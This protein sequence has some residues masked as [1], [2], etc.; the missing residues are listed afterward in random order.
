MN[1]HVIDFYSQKYASTGYIE[2][3]VKILQVAME[4]EK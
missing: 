1:Q 4:V 3:L 2:L